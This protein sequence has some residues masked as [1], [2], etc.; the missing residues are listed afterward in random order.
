[1]LC[2]YHTEKLVGLQEVEIKS[3][4]EENRQTVIYAGL[5][6]KKHRC[7]CCDHQTDKVHDYRTQDI[8]DIPAFGKNVIIRFKKRRYR[9]DGC[10]KRFIESIEWLP[11][12]YR[13][14]NRLAAYVID[15]L[16][17]ERSYSSVGREVNLSVTTV[18]RLFDLVSY[19]SQPMPEVVGIDEFKGNAGGDK[20]QCIITDI[21]NRRVLDILPNRY[22]SDLVSYFKGFDRSKTTSFVSDMW[23]PYTDIAKTFFKNASH[24][25]DKYHFI[26][27]VFWAFEAVRKAEQKKHRKDARLLFKWSKTLLNKRYEFL[28]ADEKTIVDSLL[29]VSTP[30]LFAHGLKERFLKILDCDNKNDAKKMLSDWILEAQES[31]LER[32]VACSNTFINWSEGIGNSFDLPYTNGFTEGCNNKIKALKRAAYGFRNFRRFRNRI[33]HIFSHQNSP[34]NKQKSAVA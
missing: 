6:R 7:P 18:I 28:N 3:V 14:T 10:G 2:A 33:L 13:M 21:K 32:F 16:R 31:E 34:Q 8:K 22:K 24:I 23:E 4:A 12:Y 9:C 27:Q 29:Y 11:K 25:V 17:E 5:V 1:M 26:R 19:P 15:K 20:Y 30:L